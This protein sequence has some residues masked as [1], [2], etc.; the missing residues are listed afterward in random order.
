MKKF[1]FIVTP[2]QQ[3]KRLDAVLATEFSE[4]SRARW[5]TQIKSGKVKIANVE[6]KSSM[7]LKTNSVISGYFPEQIDTNQLVAPD[8]IPPIL[9]KNSNVIV[10]NKPAGLIVHPSGKRS[11]PSVAGA[12]ASLV[13]DDDV[14]RPGIVH[15]L[16]KDTS[17]VMILARNQATKEFLQAQFKA[18]TVK[19]IYLALVAG[20]LNNDSARIELPL[21]RSKKNPEKMIVTN[22]G[23]SAISEYTA[24]AK[25]I[26]FSLLKIQ[27]FTGRTHQIR[28]QFAH[29]G[30]PVIGDRLYGT[31]GLPKG[32]S[33]QFLHASELTIEI[34]KGQIKHFSAPLPHDLESFLEKL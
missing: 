27:L 28:S 26:G 4:F 33:R 3:G 20:H 30:H 15:R 24:V 29:L 34:A 13:Q 9:F 10:I 31:S 5:N 11:Q 12:F 14:L 22:L 19:K 7:V 32:L 2:A 6:V 18:R 8:E 16:D 23:K 25:F 21:Q 17:G 1:T